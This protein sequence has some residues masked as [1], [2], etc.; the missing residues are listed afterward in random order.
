MKTF[1]EYPNTFRE[2]FEILEKYDLV[3]VYDETVEDDEDLTQE[4]LCN[5][6]KAILEKN[7]KGVA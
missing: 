2:L 4:D 7:L 6:I 1:R 3:H 5:I